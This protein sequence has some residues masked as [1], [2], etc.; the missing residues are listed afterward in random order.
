MLDELK[1][2]QRPEVIGVGSAG[3][4]RSLMPHCLQDHGQ[5]NGIESR[6]IGG[7]TEGIARRI[8]RAGVGWRANK[9]LREELPGGHYP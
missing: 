3:T 1:R 9:T 2:A 8:Q 7:I 6:K 5:E 4:L